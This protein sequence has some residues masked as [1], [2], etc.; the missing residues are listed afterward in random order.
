MV[1]ERREGGIFYSSSVGDDK[2]NYPSSMQYNWNMNIPAYPPPYNELPVASCDY[3]G[4]K[5]TNPVCF[6][7]I[8]PICWI[9]KFISI[10]RSTDFNWEDFVIDTDFWIVLYKLLFLSFGVISCVLAL[11][12][13]KYREKFLIPLIIYIGLWTLKSHC[14]IFYEIYTSLSIVKWNPVEIY[15]IA[16][17]RNA[18]DLLSCINYVQYVPIF[19]CS[20]L[21]LNFAVLLGYHFTCV[22]YSRYEELARSREMSQNSFLPEEVM[23]T[24]LYQ[25]NMLN[26]ALLAQWTLNLYYWLDLRSFTVIKSWLKIESW[27]SAYC[28]IFVVSGF[29]ISMDVLHGFFKRYSQFNVFMFYMVATGLLSV[30]MAVICMIPSLSD[31]ENVYNKIPYFKAKLADIKNSKQRIVNFAYEPTYELSLTMYRNLISIM[32]IYVFNLAP[33]TV[34]YS[35]Y[36]LAEDNVFDDNFGQEMR[37][38]QPR[39]ELFEL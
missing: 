26:V 29:I 18:R 9:S 4:A 39:E 21:F 38:Y 35:E 12:G 11:I 33:L 6:S 34:F 28:I 22:V 3:T 1:E 5:S 24:A 13:L 2:I 30:F 19:Y 17:Q 36:Q 23:F 25:H 37:E 31:I 14:I 16:I 32:F 10:I 27:V 7:L 20:V 15:D 8:F